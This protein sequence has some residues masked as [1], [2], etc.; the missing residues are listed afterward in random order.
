MKT[1]QLTGRLAKDF[2]EEFELDVATPAEAI[3]AL[4]YQLE[5]FEQALREGAYRLFRVFT[6]KEENVDEDYIQLGYGKAIGFRI[7]P[8][9]G[10]AKRGMGKVVL[11]AVIIGA[12]FLTAGLAAAPM[13]AGIFGSAIT[14]G[15]VA[16]IGGMIALQGVSMMLTPTIKNPTPSGSVDQRESFLIDATGNLTS[17][18]NP[19]P[20]VYGLV[21]VGS[22]VISTGVRTEEV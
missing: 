2:G 3:R 21:H 1:L 6:D 9:V 19:V 17:Q 15:N 5:G 4:C 8:I 12:A 14:Y 22:V 11:G 20:L 13:T 16:M 7:E 10:G 18:G